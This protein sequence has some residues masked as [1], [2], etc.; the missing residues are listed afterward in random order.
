[1]SALGDTVAALAVHMLEALQQALS[2][3]GAVLAACCKTWVTSPLPDFGVYANYEFIQGWTLVSRAQYFFIKLNDVEGELIDVK[4]GL[5][6]QFT[7]GWRLSVAYNY[8]KV[9]VDIDQ[10]SA[11]KD[12]K[13]ADY[14]I[15]YSFIGP[16]LSVSYTF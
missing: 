13:V 16:M 11:D 5:D 8:Y 12:A 15:Y 9:D 3:A 7:S 6:A 10:K 1:M 2:S 4:L 14:N